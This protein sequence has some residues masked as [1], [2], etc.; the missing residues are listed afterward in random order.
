MPIIYFSPLNLQRA[1]A[2]GTRIANEFVRP[3]CPTLG[4]VLNVVRVPTSHPLGASPISLQVKN[5]NSAVPAK[6]NVIDK[7][8]NSV[9]LSVVQRS[10]SGSQ[11]YS[12]FGKYSNTNLTVL[13]QTFP[14]RPLLK[15][16]GIYTTYNSKLHKNTSAIGL[17][18]KGA[19]DRQLATEDIHLPI[20]I[21]IAP[22]YNLSE[23][24]TNEYI[25]PIE[26]C[27][28][29]VL[30]KTISAPNVIGLTCTDAI[31]IPVLYAITDVPEKTI[32]PSNIA[33][34][35]SLPVVQRNVATSQYY[36]DFGVQ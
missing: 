1:L 14:Q 35:I 27:A 10:I 25:H 13:N 6:T 21:T 17:T 2:I 5:C 22:C 20:S 15:G 24:Y 30:D 12:D 7:I 3:Y 23:R 29:R 18:V 16:T 19:F 33:N 11:Y 32:I 8:A 31:S 4:S 26:G 28:I 36:S 34:T 9:G